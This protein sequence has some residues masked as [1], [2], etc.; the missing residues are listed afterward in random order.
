MQFAVLNEDAQG[1]TRV[2]LV[3]DS[4]KLLLKQKHAV[5]VQSGAG[6]A[7]SIPDA[8]FE[9]AGARIVAGTA[10]LLG[11]ADCLLQI[12]PVSIEDALR[13]PEG[14]AL[15]GLLAPLRNQ[16]LVQILA[17]RRVTSF[18]LDAIPRI[19]RAQSM[20]TLSSMATIAGYRAVLL[21]ASHL[22]K[23]LPMLTTAA[24]TIRPSQGLILGAGVAGLQAIATAR[25][26][27]AVVE[28]FDVRP[29]VKEQVKSLGAAFVE[30]PAAENLEDNGGY[31]KEVSAETLARQQKLLHQRARLADFIIS[32][33]QVPGKPAPRLI[34]KEMVADM[35]PGSVIVDLAAESGGNCELTQ[36]D[37]VV[38][39][40]GVTILGPTNL[41]ATLPLDASRMFGRNLATFILEITNENGFTMDWKNEIFAQTCI[42]LNGEANSKRR[43]A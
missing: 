39:C 35:K 22:P 5:L 30:I 31:A 4:I 25:R 41:P 27:G 42:T 8:H 24:G 37:Q 15:I 21:A 32:T 10:E 38:R 43:A 1:E 40:N 13:V 16:G 2:A 17:Q 28:A 26:M 23:F 7:A 9:A 12:R 6:A 3:P 14:K 36:A 20:D 33:A 18:S 29:A 19:S 11:M 34:T